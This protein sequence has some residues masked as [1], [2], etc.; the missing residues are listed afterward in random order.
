MYRAVGSAGSPGKIIGPTIGGIQKIGITAPPGKTAVSRISV[1]VPRAIGRWASEGAATARRTVSASWLR[2]GKWTCANQLL[3]LFSFFPSF[4]FYLS[5]TLGGCLSWLVYRAEKNRLAPF[6]FPAWTTLSGHAHR[7]WSKWRL[8]VQ[9][10][11]RA[12]R[13][14]LCLGGLTPTARL[15]PTL[16]NVQRSPMAIVGQRPALANG[17]RW[18]TSSAG[19]CAVLANAPIVRGVGCRL[20]PDQGWITDG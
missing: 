14:P 19:Q 9:R 18:P 16:A 10:P 13:R 17:H 3:P 4:P 5:Y 11:N 20:V 7:S 15:R 2:A 6:S 1:L 8:L 12:R